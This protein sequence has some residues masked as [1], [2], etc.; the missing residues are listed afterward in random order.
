MI[1]Q[2]EKLQMGDI[3][4]GRPL[5]GRG[6]ADDILGRVKKAMD[7]A[8]SGAAPEREKYKTAERA[9]KAR[10]KKKEKKV[11]MRQIWV[12][13]R[14]VADAAVIKEVHIPTQEELDTFNHKK[15][16]QWEAE[17][18]VYQRYKTYC[19]NPTGKL[20]P[21]YQLLSKNEKKATQDAMRWKP[22]RPPP[23]KLM[24]VGD[25]FVWQPRD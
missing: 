17:R 23:R 9:R 5:R 16:F 10:G 20:P 1:Q 8:P 13:Q 25:E 11:V 4:F 15:M 24:R 14:S 2:F 22:F 12:K 6:P 19:A 3:P 7:V 18:E 21:C